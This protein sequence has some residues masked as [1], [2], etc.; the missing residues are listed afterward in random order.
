MRDREDDLLDA[1]TRAS[2]EARWES[3]PPPDPLAALR[4]MPEPPRL[5]DPP[6][7]PLDLF[8]AEVRDA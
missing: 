5:V 2:L 7:P 6:P 4:P 8:D 3:V 1:A